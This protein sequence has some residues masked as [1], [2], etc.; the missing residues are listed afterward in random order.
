MLADAAGL[1]TCFEAS[2]KRWN[3][4]A[5]LLCAIA[6]EETDGFQNVP[7]PRDHEA[8][9]P[10]IYGVMGL[11][12]DA[13]GRT[14]DE[15]AAVSGHS[16]EELIQSPCANI[17]GAAALLAH[18]LKASGG[19]IGNAIGR[20]WVSAGTAAEVA[21]LLREGAKDG[22][23]RITPSL[24]LSALVGSRIQAEPLAKG[25]TD[26][27]GATWDPSGNFDANAAKPLYIVMHTTEGAFDGA[28]SWLKDRSSKVSAH[29]VIRK[30]DGYVKQLVRER[31]RAWHARCWNGEAIGIEMEGFLA[32]SAT[33]TPALLQAA[34]KL[35]QDIAKRHQIKTDNLHI[36]GHNFWE[37][38]L[39][40]QTPLPL[41]NDHTD[42]GKYF[43][44]TR[45]L[46]MVGQ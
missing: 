35:A 14:L 9:H 45:F 32:D 27:A 41:C 33:F 29:Y 5:P 25:G 21:R 44:W 15:A 6:R 42:P 7:D 1:D 28:V 20:I 10:K 19:E 18:E 34:S 40:H 2:A 22:R 8:D 24:E 16:R 17:D 23:I 26:Y 11:R 39:I 13:L 12:E 43:P 36:I 31:D 46:G 30:R 4:P 38:P 37:S 3:V